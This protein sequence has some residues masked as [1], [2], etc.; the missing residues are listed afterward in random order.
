MRNASENSL[1]S[2][3]LGRRSRD[4]RGALRSGEKT[5]GV[6]RLVAR[7]SRLPIQCLSANCPRGLGRKGR[8]LQAGRGKPVRARYAEGIP[9]LSPLSA[10]PHPPAPPPRPLFR[11]SQ[12]P[13][14]PCRPFPP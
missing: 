4:V 8:G 2:L 5:V 9:Q 7:A 1:G 10:G 12:S 14:L 11:P 13:H 3:H 6:V